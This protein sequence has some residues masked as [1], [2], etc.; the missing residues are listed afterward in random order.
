MG[1]WHGL[2]SKQVAIWIRISLPYINDIVWDD[3][4]HI[5]FSYHNI[6]AYVLMSPFKFVSQAWVDYSE[7]IGS[8][9]NSVHIN[10]AYLIFAITTS[11]RRWVARV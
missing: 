1:I 5:Y 4:A 6:H 7:I 9:T 3:V 2:F 8:L 11:L 10:P